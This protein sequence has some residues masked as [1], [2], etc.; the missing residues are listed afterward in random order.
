MS[1]RLLMNSFCAGPDGAVPA[2]AFFKDW[3]ARIAKRPLND[4]LYAYAELFR[5]AGHLPIEPPGTPPTPGFRHY[6]V[7]NTLKPLYEQVPPRLREQIVVSGAVIAEVSQA[8]NAAP[9]PDPKTDPKIDPK[10]Y[11]RVLAEY[12]TYHDAAV[13]YCR[14]LA[15]MLV[16]GARTDAA[17]NYTYGLSSVLVGDALAKNDPTALV[18]AL[19]MHA[20]FMAPATNWDQIWTSDIPPL[21]KAL[22]DRKADEPTYAFLTKVQNEA[23]L[24][25]AVA[26]ALLL[27]KAKAGTQIPGIIPVGPDDPSYDLYLA[28]HDLSIGDEQHAWELTG[29]RLKLLVQTWPA[30][31]PSYVAWSVE[32][33][34]KQK[35]LKD[36]LE[37]SFN[38][39]LH[40]ADID[41]DNAAR[42][43]LAKGDIYRDMEN[44]Q[45]A[46][47]EYEGLK[48]N[49]RYNK[50]DAGGKAVYRLVDLYILTKDYS[51]A[52][53]LLEHL[54][55]ADNVQ[56]QADAYYLYAK[57]SFQ[58]GDFKESR[59]YLKKV[60]ERVLNHVEA[61]LLEGELNLVLPGGLQ[62]TEVAIGDSRLSTVVIPGRQLTLTLQDPN[63]SI[64]RGGAAIPVVITTSK[65]GDVEHVKLLP[66]SA[67]KNLFSAR[68]ATSLGRAQKD[69]LT[70]ELRGDDVVSYEIEPEFQKANDLKYPPK[71]LDV[72]YDARLVASSGEILTEEEEEKREL[73][74]QLEMRQAGTTKRY[75]VNRDGRT[76]RPGSK[77]FVQVTDFCRDLTDEQDKIKVDLKTGL[78]DT[79]EGV[80]LTETGPH[81]G[82]FRGGVP[83]G[84]PDPLRLRFRYG[85]RP[86][87][88]FGYRRKPGR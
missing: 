43:L 1:T 51:A 29:P 69:N 83:T 86:W 66:S 25:E 59:D 38:I 11:P 47:I 85:R 18:R 5:S 87:S 17:P 70:L 21:L 16:D 19:W 26:K 73:E 84:V 76:I 71:K 50:T 61:A 63:L 9:P 10:T 34:R 75:E 82:V 23:H 52:E 72:R 65:G 36:G 12:R 79:L 62:N 48:G 58:K 20:G 74:R 41:A 78:G 24:P 81:T 37:F 15:E 35:L 30:M 77:I 4:Q 57:M 54:V 31:D 44:Y 64:A 8:G 55:D 67:N 39:L 45:A 88:R 32:Q 6:I 40:E 13:A 7:F 33:L 68:I 80:E 28:A 60:K 27:V 2:D 3:S 49:N 14:A 56:Q 46:R 22:D 42:I 53:S